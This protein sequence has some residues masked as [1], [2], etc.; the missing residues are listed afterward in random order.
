MVVISGTVIFTA[1][2]MQ[3]TVRKADL[4]GSMTTQP[5]A[6]FGNTPSIFGAVSLQSHHHTYLRP[7]LGGSLAPYT[8]ILMD[9]LSVLPVFIARLFRKSPIKPVHE[10]PRGRLAIHTFAILTVVTSTTTTSQR[11]SLM[12]AMALCIVA[13]WAT[14][15]FLSRYR[16]RSLQGLY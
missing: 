3:T 13:L 1:L 9:F 6:N 15:R 16:L 7:D 11:L 8:C 4:G 12:P 5:W 10:S 14:T 2:S